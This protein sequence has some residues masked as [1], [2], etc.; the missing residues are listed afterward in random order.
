SASASGSTG[1]PASPRPPALLRLEAR[2]AR[3]HRPPDR[4]RDGPPAHLDHRAVRLTLQR[5]AVRRTGQGGDELVMETL[6]EQHLVSGNSTWFR[7]V[8]GVLETPEMKPSEA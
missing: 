8:A 1:P 6:W 4:R 7:L 3:P 2:V 5:C